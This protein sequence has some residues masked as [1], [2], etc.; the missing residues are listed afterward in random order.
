MKKKVIIAHVKEICKNLNID[1]FKI[2]LDYKLDIGNG[3]CDDYYDSNREIHI[4]VKELKGFFNTEI[5]NE[6]F[7]KLIV[8]LYH[9]T[10][11]YYQQRNFF[12]NANLTEQDL[13]FFYNYLACIGN[14]YGYYNPELNPYNYYNNIRELDAEYS[15][16]Q[17]A[18]DYL[19]AIFTKEKSESFIINY[20]NNRLKNTYYISVNEPISTL[21][22]INNIFKRN[23][24]LNLHKSRQ[25]NVNCIHQ[26]KPM[27]YIQNENDE[28]V[29]KI[30]EI[31]DGLLQD[32]LM[33]ST[34]VKYLEDYNIQNNIKNNKTYQHERN[35]LLLEIQNLIQTNIKKENE[36][37]DRD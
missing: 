20:V 1:N 30:N 13:T 31:Q 9:E 14:S 3:Y 8:N 22:E 29:L 24:R 32:K 18:F 21:E 36:N 10:Q 37:I 17:N 2:I 6:L 27:Q 35:T 19:Q 12:E 11:H 25:Y 26:D 7:V 5:P 16:I 28:F 15:G 4:G 34:Y 23:I 33:A